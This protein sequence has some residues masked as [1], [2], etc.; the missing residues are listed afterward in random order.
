LCLYLFL[1]AT[2]KWE[3]LAYLAMTALMVLGII[4]TS[5]RGAVLALSGF[6]IYMWWRSRKKAVGLVV[7]AI[8]AVGAL[9]FASD[10]FF[11]RM[12]TLTNYEA[13]GSAM[14]RITT[15]TAA[16]QMANDHP[17]LGVGASHF[18]VKFGVEYRPKDVEGPMLWLN[19][20]SIFFQ[21]LAEFG[22]TGIVILVGSL[23][24]C[25]LTGE[26]ILMQVRRSS[27]E[28]ARHYEVTFLCLNASLVAF[29]VGAAFL[30]AL[31]YPH[32]YVMMALYSAAEL[33]Y[34]RDESRIFAETV[35]GTS[36]QSEFA[37]PTV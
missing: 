34:R 7:I 23:L 35:Q 12:G 21:M 31:Y 6:M 36:R 10:L 22:Y 17:L 11:E 8:G 1:D 32:W 33:M 18:R 5:S 20:H 13:E 30:S 24:Y 9:F 15:W 4:G 14:A 29:A 37:N 28:L 26:R 16:T 25:F 2:K 3:R 27:S 19:A